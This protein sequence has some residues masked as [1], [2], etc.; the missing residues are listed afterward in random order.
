[1]KE[2][3]MLID[4]HNKRACLKNDLFSED[5]SQACIVSQFLLYIK[6]RIFSDG[7][8]LFEQLTILSKESFS[9]AKSGWYESIIQI[10]RLF[11]YLLS[12][13]FSFSYKAFAVSV[14]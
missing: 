13:A 7:A 8:F 1:M 11:M 6:F 9:T 2:L 3:L 5:S 4:M 12:S 10:M 14:N